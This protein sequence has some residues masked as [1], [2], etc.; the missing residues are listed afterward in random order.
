MV[1]SILASRSSMA[2][3]GCSVT[4]GLGPGPAHAETTNA[5][6]TSDR[7]A[8]IVSRNFMQD[9][10]PVIPTVKTQANWK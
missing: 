6:I 5:D 10:A 1:C 3:S 7:R 4:G 8:T 9:T 2:T